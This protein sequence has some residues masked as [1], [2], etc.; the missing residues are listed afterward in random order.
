VRRAAT[1]VT[2]SGGGWNEEAWAMATLIWWNF[3]RARAVI[4]T[5]MAASIEIILLV[6][7]SLLW[8]D[9]HLLVERGRPGSTS[10]SRSVAFP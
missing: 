7:R 6:M 3:T 5:A 4:T 2:A 8:I 1:V 10:N 9:P